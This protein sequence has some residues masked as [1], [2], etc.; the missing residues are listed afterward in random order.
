M[1][2]NAPPQFEQLPI[3]QEPF[4]SFQAD[5]DRLFNN[6]SL[7]EAQHLYF[8]QPAGYQTLEQPVQPSKH[9]LQATSPLNSL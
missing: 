8:S 7:N 6:P 5:C 9:N 4:A 1:S 2:W 3:V